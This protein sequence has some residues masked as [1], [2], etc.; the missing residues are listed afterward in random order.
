[1]H[2]TEAEFETRHFM[3]YLFTWTLSHKL[4]SLLHIFLAQIIIFTTAIE[5]TPSSNLVIF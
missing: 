5:E 4:L 1:M 2:D 3:L